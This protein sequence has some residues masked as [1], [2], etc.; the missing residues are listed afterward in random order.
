MMERLLYREEQSFRQSFVP[1]IMLISC[2]MVLGG[3]SVAFYQQ[4]YLGKPYGDNPESDQSLIWSSIF[5]FIVM[6]AV[7][8]FILNRTLVTEIWSDGIRYKF[9]PVVRKMKHIPLSQIASVEVSKY[10]PIAEFGGWGWRRRLIGRKR[11]FSVSGRIGMRIIMKNGR[12]LMFGTR[13]QDDVKRAV[14]K[15]MQPDINKYS[16]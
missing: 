6:A 16:I 7:F 10:R 4:F 9:P 14:N 13:H 1:W 5:S 15:M 8:I 12:Q 11:A 2:L 3:F